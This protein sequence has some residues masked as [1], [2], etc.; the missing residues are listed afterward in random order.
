MKYVALIVLMAAGCTAV[1]TPDE[2]SIHGFYGE[3]TVDG[4]QGAN[5]VAWPGRADS[6]NWTVGGTLTWYI[7][8]PDRGNSYGYK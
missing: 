8:Q 7:P 6:E 5:L 4:A 3:G 1:N 2:F